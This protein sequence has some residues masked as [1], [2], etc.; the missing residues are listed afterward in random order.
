MSSEDLTYQ[1]I[2][3]TLSSVDCNEH[4]EKKGGL[5]YLSW[6]WA[7]QILME[8]YAMATFEFG[9]NETH[10]DG[11]MTVHCTVKIGECQRSM[12]LPV[13][14]YKNAAII[15]P[16]ARDISDNKMRC[17][18]KTLALMGLGHYIYSGEDTV[19]AGSTAQT[20]ESKKKQSPVIEQFDPII[21]LI[22][23]REWTLEE[24]MQTIEKKISGIDV[25]VD[26]STI[27]ELLEFIFITIVMF[28]LPPEGAPVKDGDPKTVAGWVEKFTKLNRDALLELYKR[29]FEVEI[30]AFHTRLNDV[31]EMSI[32]ELRDFQK[33]FKHKEGE[34]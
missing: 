19:N 15:N 6:A 22:D 24:R 29:G 4:T 13:M 17:L 25:N 3:N 14:N 10:I 18:T 28:A 11:S 2:W 20:V 8:H 34:Y 23:G 1:K 30:K 26:L 32:E 31:R 7:W 21:A 16:N 27:D 33:V 5:T 12:W 9:E